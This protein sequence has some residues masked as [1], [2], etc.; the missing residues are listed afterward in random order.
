MT[1]HERKILATT[2]A[3]RIPLATNDKDRKFL[4]DFASVVAGAA[5]GLLLAFMFVVLS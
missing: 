1:E 2:N 4:N 5:M 3:V